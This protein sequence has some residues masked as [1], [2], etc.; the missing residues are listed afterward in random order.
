M[1]THA[2]NAMRI[3][4][5]MK[6][7][8]AAVRSRLI[9]PV[10]PNRL[11][12]VQFNALQHLH[13]YGGEPG[14]TISELGEHLGLAHN[15][16]SG[17]VDRLERD[18]WT[19]RRKCDKD[20]RQSRVQLTAQAEQLFREGMERETDFW[21]RTIGQ[22]TPEEQEGLINNLTRLTQVMEK[23]VWPSYD[24]LH[25]RDPSHL[26]E[27]WK[28][29]LDEL[30]HSKLQSIG[31]RLILAQMAEQQHQ[32]E[33]AAYL[34]QVASE[35]IRHTNQVFAQLGE[36]KSLKMALANL[37]HQDRI[38]LEALRDLVETAQPA[39]HSESLEFLQQM[40]QDNQRYKRWFFNMLKQMDEK[41]EAVGT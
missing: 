40:V 36:R 39:N 11:T 38:V 10:V 3:M 9:Q 18:G 8:Q 28:A 7:A 21:H 4:R 17:L 6:L 23:P 31:T 13:W 20:R 29:E 35:E 26:Q 24:Q 30:A 1:S 27:R 14:M 19:T 34:K 41:D 33:L 32:H 25:P 15:T 5:M 12:I 16:V 2:E 22:L 37:V